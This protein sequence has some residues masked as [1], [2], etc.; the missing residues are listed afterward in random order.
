MINE[1]EMGR[2]DDMRMRREGEGKIVRG[3]R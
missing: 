1:N 3:R 2:E